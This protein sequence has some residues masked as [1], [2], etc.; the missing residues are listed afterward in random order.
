MTDDRKIL[1][2]QWIGPARILPELG[3]VRTDQFKEL[4]EPVALDYIEQGL[5]LRLRAAKPKKP[6]ET[7]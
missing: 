6:E 4:P 1:K 3:E 2:I 5:A 7:E